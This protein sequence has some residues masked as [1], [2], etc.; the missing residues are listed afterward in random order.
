MLN[1]R[2]KNTLAFLLVAV[3]FSLLF[4]TRSYAALSIA[5]V[6]SDKLDWQPWTKTNVQY[7]LFGGL[8]LAT[9]GTGFVTG[10][11]ATFQFSPGGIEN[12]WV[13][14]TYVAQDKVNVAGNT[15]ELT[16]NFSVDG[17]SWY[18][19][20][21]L[22]SGSIPD[23]ASLY[24][25]ATFHNDDGTNT[26]VLKSLNLNYET[27]EEPKLLILKRAFFR[28]EGTTPLGAETAT[29]TP[30]NAVV[31]KIKIDTMGL[32]GLNLLVRDYRPTAAATTVKP[33]TTT[34]DCGLDA[35]YNLL[36][37]D[38]SAN[39][40]GNY[41]QWSNVHPPA[42]IGYLCYQ[43]SVSPD[44]QPKNDVI[45]AK[46]IA[47][48]Q[49]NFNPDQPAF[50]PMLANYS[51]YLMV[52]GMAFTNSESYS[53]DNTTGLGNI[54]PIE[55]FLSFARTVVRYNTGTGQESN[56]SY[57]GS[58]VYIR[59]LGP[60]SRGGNLLSLPAR[61]KN[62]TAT[63][64]ATDQ[65]Y[66]LYNPAF[67]LFGNLFSG[68]SLAENLDFSSRHSSVAN[69]NFPSDMSSKLNSEASLY[70]YYFDQNS[71]L[72]WDNSSST[73]ETEYK[74]KQMTES[75]KSLID[76]KPSEFCDLSGLSNEDVKYML[77]DTKDAYLNN[78]N[79]FINQAPVTDS[80]NIYPNGRVWYLTP[81]GDITLSATL[82]NQGTIIVDY[83]NLNAGTVRIATKNSDFTTGAK[84]G[85]IVIN[86]G[87]VLFTKEAEAFNGVIFDP[88]K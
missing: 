3:C 68:D 18:S 26:P 5:K 4:P 73:S 61:M 51:A 57:S 11:E 79:C 48:D 30:G 6:W 64:I 9:S 71:V 22:N 41:T 23:S 81:S 67:Y 46:V 60:K 52:K 19:I 38:F 21:Q 63:V 70:K 85:L 50:N 14:S 29:L 47:Y 80:S 27:K 33:I 69:T 65:S 55:D 28:G 37:G 49:D 8:R 7:D 77:S 31:I 13:G 40:N 62:D 20:D 78:R 87:K 32:S 74:N 58:Y 34:A 10:G 15:N 83:K 75:I 17:A 66:V 12:H 72:Y 25:K 44:T 86:G 59:G 36:T 42:G 43:Y 54:F 1:T 16:L 82:H 53:T 24:I 45:Q 56:L 88:G 35:S 84:I 39:E 76:N 2:I